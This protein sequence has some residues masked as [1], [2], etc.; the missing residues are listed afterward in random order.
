[1]D[2]TPREMSVGVSPPPQHSL[3]GMYKC[4]RAIGGWGVTSL[5]YLTSQKQKLGLPW[6]QELLLSIQEGY[7]L[8]T[9]VNSYT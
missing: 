6:K 7:H 1:M 2:L 4:V 8:L 5:L 9:L 3:L